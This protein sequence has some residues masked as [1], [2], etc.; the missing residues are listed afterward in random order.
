MFRYQILFKCNNETEERIEVIY[1]LS[2]AKAV[3]KLEEKYKQLGY[4]EVDVL[5]VKT[6]NWR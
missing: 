4:K 5:G 1:A 6:I 2:P 3:D